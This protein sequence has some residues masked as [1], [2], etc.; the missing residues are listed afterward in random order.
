MHKGLLSSRRVA[1]DGTRGQGQCRRGLFTGSRA[2]QICQ[3]FPVPEVSG[4]S[5][6]SNPSEDPTDRSY[7]AI[8]GCRGA[9]GD[10]HSALSFNLPGAA[11]SRWTTR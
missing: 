1:Q 5:P 3:Q 8:D 9:T 7:I 10:V 2:V 4:E 6:A 11:A